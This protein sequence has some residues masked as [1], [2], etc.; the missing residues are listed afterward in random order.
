[1]PCTAGGWPVTIERLLGLVKHGTTQSASRLVP[2]VQHLGEPRR[3]TGLD[4]AL[5]VARLGAVD[6][7]HDDGLPAAGDSGGR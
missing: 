1:M 3:A 7:D 6:A 2:C 4:R 5:D